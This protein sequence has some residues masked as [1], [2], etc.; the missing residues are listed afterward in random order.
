MAPFDRTLALACRLETFR[1][2]WIEVEC[3]RGTRQLPV[4]L[5]LAADPRRG[6]R[7]AR[8]P[9]DPA[10]VPG[11][12]GAAGLGGAGGARGGPTGAQAGYGAP[13]GWRLELLG[14]GETN[15]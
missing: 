4:W 6:S 14:G 5:V 8:R 2:D 13:A 15:G 10:A 1:A 11:V 12:R 7:T 9:P 3:C